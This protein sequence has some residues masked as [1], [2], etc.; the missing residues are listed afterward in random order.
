MKKRVFS[1]LLAITLV[2]GMSNGMIS[3][4]MDSSV[5]KNEV[6]EESIDET[7]LETEL[8]TE[9]SELATEEV[10]TED[11]DEAAGDN[12]NSSEEDVRESEVTSESLAEE[13]EESE[14]TE[15]EDLEKTNEKKEAT[16]EEISEEEIEAN[17]EE[18]L[19]EKGEE[20]L[21]EEEEK[22]PFSKHV[23][24]DGCNIYMVA[25]AGVF[26]K[27]AYISAIRV[28]NTESI[29]AAIEAE[30]DDTKE[31]KSIQ[32]F[33]IKVYNNHGEVIQPD[34]SYGDVHVSVQ[35]IDT[36]PAMYSENISME[37][38]HMNKELNDAEQI[39]S[40]LSM[41]KVSF[42]AKGFSTYAVVKVVDAQNKV[43]DLSDPY[44]LVDELKIEGLDLSTNKDTATKISK[45]TRIKV[46]YIFKNSPKI[47]LNAS[48]DEM[49][50]AG[51]YIKKGETYRLPSIPKE[52]ITD[53]Q[54]GNIKVKIGSQDLGTISFDQETGEASFAVELST[55]GSKELKEI[56]AGFELQLHLNLAND[57]DKEVYELA[58]GNTKYYVKLSEKMAQ[59]PTITKK[60]ADYSEAN[61]DITWQIEIVNNAK[62]IEYDNGL[63][64]KD[65]IGAGQVYVPSS[66]KE[67]NG[68]TELSADS[69]TDKGILVWNCSNDEANHSAVFQYKT[70]VDFLALTK[71]ENEAKTIKNKVTNSVTVTGTPKNLQ[72]FDKLNVT[73][74]AEQEVSKEVNSWIEK[75]GGELSDTGVAQFSVTIN[76]NGYT[77]SELNLIDTIDA[78][79][80]V[81]IDIQNLKINK[82]GTELQRDTGF[83]A[84]FDGHIQDIKFKD[85]LSGVATIVVTYDAVIKDYAKYLKQNHKIPSNSAYIK[86]KY[87]SNGD[88][89]EDT[90]VQG[91]TVTKQFKGDGISENAALKKIC[92]GYDAANQEMTWQI[93]VNDNLQNIYNVS[94]IDTLPEG[95]TYVV[96]SVSGV[97]GTTI[98]KVDDTST[99]GKVIISLGKLE[100]AKA[101]FTLKTKL[102]N[103]QSQY[104]ASNQAEKEYINS[105][106]LESKDAD[107]TPNDEV[108]ATAKGKYIS[109]VLKKSAGLYNYNDHTIRYELTLN[110]N[111]MKMTGVKVS[112]KLAS[113][114]ELLPE[115]VNINNGNVVF[116]KAYNKETNTLELTFGELTDT[117]VVEFKAKIADTT[118]FNSNK[119]RII[120]NQAIIVSDQYDKEVKSTEVS[121]TI[122]N[123]NFE[124]K[125]IAADDDIISYTIKIN[126]A[127]EPIYKDD[128]LEVYVQDILGESLTL[129]KNSIHLY[130]ASVDTNGDMKK[131]TEVNLET[132][133]TKVFGKN[134]RK[135]VMKVILPKEAQGKAYI[136][137]YKAAMTDDSAKD[138][139]NDATLMG[140][141]ASTGNTSS[142]DMK[143]T[144]WSNA[145]INDRVYVK[146]VLK[147]KKNEK[148]LSGGLFGLYDGEI[149]IDENTTNSNGVIYFVGDLEEGHDYKLR[150]EGTP[151][152]YYIPDGEGEKIVTAIKSKKAADNHP[153][154][155]YNIKKFKEI[156][157]SLLDKDDKTTEL[158]K[159]AL[160]VKEGATAVATP[161]SSISSFKATYGVVYSVNESTI[162]F[163]YKGLFKDGCSFVVKEDTGVL[164]FSGTT[165]ENAEIIGDT[166]KAYDERLQSLEI[167]VDDQSTKQN[168]SL[169]GAKLVLEAVAADDTTTKVDE[170]DSTGEFIN[171]TLP[172]GNY[173]LTRTTAPKGY[174]N[175]L[176]TM[177][178]SVSRGLLGKLSLAVLENDENGKVKALDDMKLIVNEDN[179]GNDT[180]KIDFGAPEDVE[181][182]PVLEVYEIETDENG[183][184][185]SIGDNPVWTSKSEE[186]F[187]AKY[188]VDYVLKESEPEEGEPTLKPVYFIVNN[189]GAV[190]TKDTIDPAAEYVPVPT[191]DDPTVDTPRIQMNKIPAPV[192]TPEPDVIPEPVVVPEPALEPEAELAEEI[193]LE[194]IIDPVEQPITSEEKRHRHTAVAGVQS[195]VNQ[196]FNPDEDVVGTGE[197]VISI[198]E[199]RPKLAQTGGFLG[200]LTGYL[201]GIILVIVGYVIAFGGRKKYKNEK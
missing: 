198:T 170:W 72:D 197:V 7:E 169:V 181:N 64:F 85:P 144:V 30:L 78:D 90:E 2:V 53:E 29:E 94:V 191:G 164:E 175:I 74:I 99:P 182:T 148:P 95:H 45:D 71:N 103:T 179:N 158:T 200:A 82:D 133:K 145:Q 105:I 126:Q 38:F 6:V 189:D 194:P 185:V 51:I 156:K 88:G 134:G 141:S 54:P 77:L 24:A 136:L 125:G 69:D 155:V 132:D 101:V 49:S 118:I 130:E 129:E 32:A 140:S 65:V 172:E 73:K 41:N 165:P 36:A 14:N 70:H 163:G 98:E 12:E 110:S 173:L 119:E 186:P 96:N 108:K 13:Q 142:V 137:E 143:A 149:K 124:K 161:A 5:N 111:R 52:C 50:S 46:R 83:S 201:T 26:P 199:G 62:P 81:V 123:I 114:L 18:E 188:Q 44:A 56:S 151:D 115:T 166:L 106:T 174:D 63:T 146:V 42:D 117:V 58:F 33:D 60:V 193:E 104:W 100:K 68:T 102:D 168:R 177:K 37:V 150:E 107:G 55:E 31:I 17:P 97:D 176:R 47:I 183:T 27:G 28:S 116:H 162:P 8:E 67:V 120:K 9:D 19:A 91:P 11:L 131:V 20:L 43:T 10:G 190:L 152:K 57:P 180:V 25:A 76:N 178:F 187:K 196:M 135:S 92:T 89:K 66:F 87:D 40:T 1:L 139:N 167:M 3:Y 79:D 48:E 160:S 128:D 39:G 157:L 80:N 195:A 147:D 171:L 113:E 61:G 138:F 86:Y 35:G 21:E 184:P 109:N 192:V 34:T 59:P 16:S 154:V 93:T 122:K 84:S 127:Q 15:E 23:I 75:T 112:D 121:T 153:S 22:E 159:G 4:G